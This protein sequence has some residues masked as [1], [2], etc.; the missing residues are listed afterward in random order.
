M[1]RTKENLR[2]IRAYNKSIRDTG[3][4]VEED[5]PRSK[6]GQFTSGAGEKAITQ[7]AEA[8]TKET[9]A[10][11]G[12]ENG[13]LNNQNDPDQKKRD[14]HANLYY[15]EI[16]HSG[17]DDFAEK[18]AAKTGMAK[19]DLVAIYNHVFTET[20]ELVEGIKHFDPSYDMAE[21]FRRLRTGKEPPLPHDIIMLK[22]ELLE[23]EIMRDY[24]YNYSKAHEMAAKK[25]NYHQATEEW[26]NGQ[27]KTDKKE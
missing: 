21:S 7:L 9:G 8:T 24:G 25:Y 18:V 20:H 4:W 6:N 26:K 13:A 1:D 12:A 11:S 10:E 2:R 27:N 17:P 14:A 3:E 23:L 22:H 15:K 5:H 19:E 16:T